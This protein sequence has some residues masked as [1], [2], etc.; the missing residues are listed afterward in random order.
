MFIFP[1]KSNKQAIKWDNITKAGLVNFFSALYFYLPIATLWYQSKG[2][3]LTQVGTL[4]GF[5]IITIFL[6]NIPTGVLADKIGR[7]LSIVIA[8]MLQVL[9]EVL[10]LFSRT[11][12]SFA[13]VAMIAGL[14]FSFMSG[15]FDAI[16]FD[17]LNEEGKQDQAQ[18]IIGSIMSLKGLST[19]IGAGVSSL[20]LS[21][22]TTSRFILAIMMTIVTV[23]CGLVVSF[24]L[25]E[26]RR[27]QEKNTG[28]IKQLFSDSL[29]LLQENSKLR[30]LVLLGILTTPFTAYLISFYQPFFKEIL[31]PGPWFGL[32]FSIGGFL[33]L[34]A[35]RYAYYFEK[36]LGSTIALL[37]FT[38][39][40]GVFF[41]LMSIAFNP[42]VAVLLFC[43]NYGSAELQGPL[44]ADYTNRHIPSEVRATLLSF[45][46]TIS[47]LYM[48]VMGPI[49]G[50]VADH[51]LPMAFLLMGVIII[52]GAVAFR[53]REQHINIYSPVA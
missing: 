21:Q 14:G 34:L 11:F 44:L 47:S 39:M 4:N 22:L 31:V 15:A 46:G 40:P 52:F 8:M 17:T 1:N 28:S 23:S 7:K 13:F 35:S 20:I 3:N 48:A 29:K 49:I 16:I 42:S 43:L 6:T 50:K 41:S 2:L 18:K 37:L 33:A 10:F 12:W 32:A 26:P 9:G 51:S 25:R 19:V 27:F 45:I 53:A 30:R 24:S 36:K 5:M 38:L